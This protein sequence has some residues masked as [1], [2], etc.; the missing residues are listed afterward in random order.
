MLTQT[1]ARHIA[2]KLQAEITPG[3]RHDIAVFRHNGKRIMQFGIQRSSK[4]QCHDYVSRQ[5]FITAKQ[6]REFRDCSLSLEAYAQ[7]LSA[8]GLLS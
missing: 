3:R 1:D 4:E 5:M 6:C 8:K 2:K 7:I